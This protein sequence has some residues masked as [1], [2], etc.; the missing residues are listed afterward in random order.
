MKRYN[1]YTKSKNDRKEYDE[2]MSMQRKSLVQLFVPIFIETLFYMLSGMVDTLMLSSLNDQAVG[3]VGT[4]NTYIAMFI[5][6]FS[7][8]SSGMMAVMTQYIGAKKPGVAYQARNLGLV[9]NLILGGIL[10]VFLIIFST[11][12]LRAIGVSA[13]L[14]APAA[15]YIRIVGGGCFLNAI[16]PIFAGYLRAFGFSKEPLYATVIGNLTNLGL[17]ALFLFYFHWGVAG[18][19]SAT[20][21]SKVINAGILI[22]C[23]FHFIKKSELIERESNRLIFGQI[24]RIGLP[25]ALETFIYNVSMTFAIRYLNQMDEQGFYVSARAYTTQIANFSYA[26]G[27]ALASAN[28]IMTGWRV[29]AGEYEECKQKT[30]QAWRIG[31]IVSMI[32][33]CLIALSAPVIVPFFTDNPKMVQM[34]TKLLWIDVVL[35]VGRVT[36]LVYGQSLKTCG[37]AIYPVILGIVFM[38]LCTV[39]GGWILGIRLQWM[40]VGCYMAMAADE[41]FRG[42]GMFLRWQSNRWQ[43]KALITAGETGQ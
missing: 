29:G 27:A 4:A 17:N 43:N 42:I 1:S 14:E 16:L 3:A 15:T 22:V 38:F 20:V 2:E 6:M 9:F 19:A 5:L 11:Q 21:I 23:A 34:V 41:C 30:R 36:N 33:S 39:V 31:L 12:I 18:V 40:V 10:S 13:A 8:V 35:E 25:S 24:I 28:A 32:L 7:V 26:A 37:D